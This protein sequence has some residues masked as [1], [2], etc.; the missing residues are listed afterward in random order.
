MSDP[1]SSEA[2]RLPEACNI[3]GV[4]SLYEQ[5]SHADFEQRVQLDGSHV[6]L[7]DTAGL[8]LLLAL[9][10]RLGSHGG[11]IEWLGVSEALKTAFE[12]VG[13][14]DFLGQVA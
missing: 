10:N 4:E 5:F 6:E 13:R 2:V 1:G 3:A 11:H 14:P 9:Q 12:L 7:I 8:Q